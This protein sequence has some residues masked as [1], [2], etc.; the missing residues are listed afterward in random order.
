MHLF[1][2]IV[3]CVNEKVI[4]QGERLINLK[5]FDDTTQIGSSYGQLIN[6]DD[7]VDD[8]AMCSL[9]TYFKPVS[10]TIKVMID[11]IGTNAET[12]LLKVV[13]TPIFSRFNMEIT[14]VPSA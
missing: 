4:T 14:A 6:T 9:H 2:S 12:N 1:A 10:Q 8:Y 13:I 5:L 3:V 7:T 11:S